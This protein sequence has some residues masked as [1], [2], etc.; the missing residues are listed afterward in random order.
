MKFITII[1]SL[2][3]S[4]A[5]HAEIADSKYVDR[6]Q[7]MLTEAIYNA[8]GAYG[9]ITQLSSAE[10]EHR[11]DQGIIDTYYTTQFELYVKID[12]G[13]RDIY[14]VEA[15][16]AQYSAYDHNAKDWGIYDVISVDCKIQ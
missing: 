5:A 13:I 6:H 11:V 2:L 9:R 4:F 12:Q 3:L 7:A 15:K 16:S 14:I 8:C 1:A 10:T